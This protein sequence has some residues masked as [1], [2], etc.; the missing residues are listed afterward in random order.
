V[1]LFYSAAHHHDRGPYGHGG[2]FRLPTT[3]TI[4]SIVIPM[5]VLDLN[6]GFLFI[7]AITSLSVYSLVLG[8]FGSNS[9]Y[10]LFAAMR[11]SAQMISY[12]I[13]MGLS[14]VGWS[15]C[16]APCISRK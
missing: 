13:V 12:E 7:L 14:L 16:T 1:L 15:W 10:P 11:S 9:K 5:R 8:G 6:V 3:L 2:Q 4:G